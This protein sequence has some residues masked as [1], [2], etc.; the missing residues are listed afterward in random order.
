MTDARGLVDRVAG[1]WLW[2]LA[3]WSLRWG[4]LLGLVAAWFALRPPR[5]AETRHA[6][7]LAALV[8]GVILPAVPRW[9]VARV[10][11]PSGGGAIPARAPAP[12]PTANPALAPGS[13]STARETP[14]GIGP[15]RP[16]VRG[17]GATRPA[18]APPG[19]PRR[20]GIVD[21]LAL[22]VAAT[23][24]SAVL[25]MACRW[26]G[27]RL[28]LAGLRRR[29]SVVDAGPG[30][31]LEECRRAVGL[32]RP[33]R[34]GSD[35]AVASPAVLGGRR[36]LV[37]VPGD[38]GSWP[39]ADRRAC[40]LHELSHLARRD[41]W[42]KLAQELVRIP[43][44]FHPLVAWLLARLDRERELLADEAVVAHGADPVAYARLLLDLAR[45]P[46]RLLI[47]PG[48][49]RP[50]WL[51]FLDRRTVAARIERLLE[52]DMPRT[53]ESSPPRRLVAL[54]AVALFATLIA[55]GLRI[56]PVEAKAGVPAADDRAL[57]G[58]VLGPDGEPVAEAV[59]VVG[60]RK[61]ASIEARTLRTDADGHFTWPL[62]P[63][64]VF[65][66][67]VAYKAGQAPALRPHHIKAETRADEITLKLGTTVP[68]EAVLLDEAGRPMAGAR[69]R[70]EMIA[71][72]SATPNSTSTSYSYVRRDALA[73]SPL[74]GLFEATTDGRGSF[75][76]NDLGPWSWVRLGAIGA[77]GRSLRVKPSSPPVGLVPS[78]MDGQG[79]V[80]APP[81]SATRL[82][83]SPAARVA[84]RV[85]TSLAGVKLSGLEVT[86]GGSNPD[87]SR[88][89]RPA[90]FGATTIT[91]EAGRFAFDGLNDG[92]V[93]IYV[94]AETLG[95]PWTSRAAADVAVRSGA[96][97]EVAIE[98]IRGVEVE[99]KVVDRESRRGIPGTMIGV[100][101][102]T[103]P[104]SS[105]MTRSVTTDAEGRYRYRLPSG[106]TYLY[107]M[108]PPPGYKTG[109][110][111]G[112][113][114]TLTIPDA[115]ARF[116]APDFELEAG[117]GAPAL[118]VPAAE[119]PR[120]VAADQLTGVVVDREGRPIEGAEADAWHWAPG[121]TAR[122]SVGG[123][124]LTRPPDRRLVGV[125]KMSPAPLRRPPA[126]L[127]RV[128]PG[129]FVA[130]L[131]RPT[132]AR[133]EPLGRE[134]VLRRVGRVPA[135]LR[136]VVVE[137]EPEARRDDLPVPLAIGDDGQDALLHQAITLLEPC[138]LAVAIGK[139]E[140]VD[141]PR[142]ALRRLHHAVEERRQQ[143]VARFRQRLLAVLRLGPG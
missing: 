39:E 6:I 84:G 78:M 41:D 43:L 85:T 21:V 89:E 120:Q 95:V 26:A 98:L 56:R 28:V 23:W 82:V 143:A 106:E 109:D 125:G 126:G 27:G 17:I 60:S 9:G 30:R 69:V 40:L 24:A 48:A 119:E 121:N 16:A 117:A 46:G 108:G 64:E 113:R 34:L 130:P 91:D 32:S 4:V 107:V 66:E 135:L 83:A 80:A 52:D 38:W 141:D 31:L 110:D 14:E 3:D 51:P 5:R 140:A 114:R 62:P 86:C 131:Q 7:C 122:W 112:S 18:V 63:G 57:K 55:G 111:E 88:P 70:I 139:L 138:P 49:S 133:L 129:E 61:Y 20:P 58:A 73:G 10:P 132:Q 29:A 72:A 94:S 92:T 13:T 116:E 101:G 33:V 12:D 68:F 103:H 81:G 65:G 59:V 128:N 8:A 99:G 136:P 67:L 97:A 127:L 22:A 104:R 115:P 75:S 35:P 50:A 36:P 79:F 15:A 2:F 42:A 96:T 124:S 105:A 102:P 45:R 77:D 1:P 90:N 25:A 137:P 118:S 53:I 54:G 123:Q 142:S 44:F 74:S 47:G 93:N 37:L 19:P 11:W 87:R 134:V 100:Y 76:F 71:T